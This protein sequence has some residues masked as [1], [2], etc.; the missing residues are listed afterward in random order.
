MPTTSVSRGSS[1]EDLD[2]AVAHLGDELVVVPLGAVHPDH[3]VEQ[4]VVAGVRGEP[5]VG[6]ARRADQHSSQASHLRPHT[7]RGGDS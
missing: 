7:D 5:E 2:V 6:Q 4:Q 1:L 3:V